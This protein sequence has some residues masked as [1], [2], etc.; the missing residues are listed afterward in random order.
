[1][2][3]RAFIL[4][5]G[6]SAASIVSPLAARA[7]QALPVVGFVYVGSADIFAGSWPRS[8]RVLAKPATSRAGT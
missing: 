5:I 2:R 8:A 4:A 7:Q 3:R 6:G 1:M